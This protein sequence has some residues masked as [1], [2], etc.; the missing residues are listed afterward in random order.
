MKKVQLKAFS[1][2]V[3]ACALAAAM[4]LSTPSTAFAAEFSD[5]FA[6]VDDADGNSS[7]T[8]TIAPDVP[9]KTDTTAI[10]ENIGAV[11]ELFIYGDSNISTKPGKE[12]TLTAALRFTEGKIDNAALKALHKQITWTTSAPEIV[13]IRRDEKNPNKCILNPRAAGSVTITATLTVVKYDEDGNVKEDTAVTFDDFV[14]VTV[15]APK[16]EEFAWNIQKADKFYVKGTYCLSDFLNMNGKSISSLIEDEDLN[17]ASEVVTYAVN[18]SSKVAVVNGDTLTVKGVGDITLFAILPDGTEGPS[19]EITTEAGSPI[20]KLIASDSKVELD[21]GEKENVIPTYDVSVDVETVDGDDTTDVI[22]WTTN[23]PSVAYVD[24]DPKKP[25]DQTRAQITAV[26]VGK[27]TITA[28]A[29]SGK[30]AKFNVTVKATLI[31]IEIAPQ[32]S[33]EYA[34]SGKTE[35]LKITRVPE[36]NKEKLK[37][38]S[39]D[40]RVKVKSVAGSVTITPAVDLKLADD[41]NKKSVGE[42][43]DAF[44]YTEVELEVTASDKNSD[45]SANTTIK[46]RQ[47]D[48]QIKKVTD[49]SVD[50]EEAKDMD[51]QTVRTNPYET[52][53]Y[54]AEL[55]DKHNKPGTSAVSW[56]SSNVNVARISNMGELTVVGSGTA[57]ITVSSVYAKSKG[58]YATSKKTFTVKSTPACDKIVLKS[59]T[60]AYDQS[61]PKKAVTI[62]IKQ[63]LSWDSK[64]AN[65]EIDWYVNGVKQKKDKKYVTDKKITLQSTA[66]RGLEAGSIVEVMAV[67]K[68]N[69]EVSAIATVYVVKPAAKKIAFRAKNV[70]LSVGESK[71]T[72]ALTVT[73]S[74]NDPVVRY[75]VDKKGKGVV[76]TE[77][78]VVKQDDGTPKYLVT[79]TGIGQGKATVTAYTASG[80]KA[81]L[82]VEVKNRSSQ[83]KDDEKE[84]EKETEK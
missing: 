49:T 41:E 69:P 67:S 45:A 78:K 37:V 22:T 57:K 14:T 23:K 5:N 61:K 9:N 38:T 48:V 68:M 66:F 43:D 19:V 51:K 8:E 31:R 63:Q 39:L 72:A 44:D 12:I 28:K 17:S 11:E 62:T 60:A 13:S 3:I 16:K 20:K 46:V 73:G 47:C 18:G 79:L 75:E 81:A 32:G 33:N 21:F 24:V 26:G 36:Q 70:S 2:R 1:K 10:N 15:R 74:K 34:W 71:D 50:P 84:D 53:T 35:E 80:K 59:D 29:T 55:S 64:K 25:E 7:K 58:K 27:A 40:K 56:A 82:K 4:I 77:A 54:Q 83:S 65:D 6:S 76:S 52:Y 42:G 30:T